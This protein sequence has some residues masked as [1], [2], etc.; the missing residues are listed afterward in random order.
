MKLSIFSG[1][2]VSS[3][4]MLSSPMSTDFARNRFATSSVFDG[5]S[6][7]DDNVLTAYGVGEDLD[8]PDVVE[9]HELVLDLLENSQIPGND[10]G[11]PGYLRDLGFSRVKALDIE[12]ASAEQA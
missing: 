10:D 3:S 1:L 5:T 11:K 4:I 9:L 6:C 12:A 8:L 2:P 7:A